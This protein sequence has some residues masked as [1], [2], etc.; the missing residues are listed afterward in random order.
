MSKNDLTDELKVQY[1]D[2]VV[3]AN[4]TDGTNPHLTT[5]ANLASKPTTFEGFGLAN[6]SVETIEST[7]SVTTPKLILATGVYVEYNSTD[8]SI[9]FVIE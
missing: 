3:H 2:D 4:T 7:T 5:Y 8:G 6:G 1:E 9:D